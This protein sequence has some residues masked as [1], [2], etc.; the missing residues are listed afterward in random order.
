MESAVRAGGHHYDPGQLRDPGGDNGGQWVAVPGA[1]EAMQLADALTEFLEDTVDGVESDDATETRAQLAAWAQHRYGGTFAGLRVEV[2][3]DDV[4]LVGD[5]IHVQGTIYDADNRK[6]GGFGRSLLRDD[7]D[8]LYARHDLLELKS[9][10][11]GQGFARAFNNHLIDGYRDGDVSRVELTANIDVGGYA[12]ARAGYDFKDD[13]GKAA[14][15]RRMGDLVDDV[16]MKSL[17]E[18]NPDAAEYAALVDKIDLIIGGVEDPTPYEISELGRDLPDA[19]GMWF[20]KRVLLGSSWE[21][22]L[23]L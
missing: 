19:D 20:G 6:V 21:G 13:E 16:I 5:G 12:W 4:A 14:V 2:A 15:G 10:V 18:D 22:V 9:S 1:A 23:W 7:D 3:P 17:D 11:Q 8:V